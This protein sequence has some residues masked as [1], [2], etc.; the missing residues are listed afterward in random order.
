[1]SQFPDWILPQLRVEV[2]GRRLTTM[3]VGG[4]VSNVLEPATA[5]EALKLFTYLSSEKKPFRVIGNGSNLILPDEWI[6]EVVLLRLA[7]KKEKPKLYFHEQ[8]FDLDI[9]NLQEIPTGDSVVLE[10]P[11]S[12]SMMN[13]SRQ[14]S[15]LG[16]SGLEYTA[17][18][19]GTLGG[20]VRMNAGAHGSQLSDILTSVRVWDQRLNKIIEY[21]VGE[22]LSFAYRHSSL[23]EDSIVLSAKLKLIKK[24]VEEVR[25]SRSSALKYR[26]ETQP[27]SMPSAGSVFRNPSG[28]MSAA[29]ILEDLGLK[30]ERVGGVRLSEM[31]SNWIVRVAD[32][33]KAM[34][35]RIL[36]DLL[37][38][39]ALKS[40]GVTLKEEII[41]W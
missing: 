36:V 38:E 29:K 30:G 13:V 31:H 32:D 8:F 37:K 12:A 28:E 18:I 19:P 23:S 10:L 26:K 14:V 4:D 9:T 35:V 6:K 41:F 7:F 1:M 2:P 40:T 39:K 16:L 17:G 24:D 22:N 11:C 21:V 33:A 20:A 3:G 27:L 25:E 34:D 15:E 5:D